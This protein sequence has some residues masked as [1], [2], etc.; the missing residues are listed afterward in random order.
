MLLPG[1]L[2]NLS[3]NNKQKFGVIIDNVDSVIKYLDVTPD[4][5]N[6]KS[7]SGIYKLRKGK[8]AVNVKTK[9]ELYVHLDVIHIA[10]DKFDVCGKLVNNKELIELVSYLNGYRV[11]TDLTREQ[12][13]S[14]SYN[15]DSLN[16]D[17]SLR[18]KP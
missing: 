3:N 11:Y 10:D 17:I 1:M 2:I 18:K 5:S 15:N 13:A 16:G 6:V 4:S 7:T 9:D 12:E 8:F 14:K